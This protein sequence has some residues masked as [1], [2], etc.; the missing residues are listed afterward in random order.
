M[1]DGGDGALV[2]V[3][4]HGHPVARLRQHLGLDAGV[5]A[6]LLHVLAL[7]FQL[8]TLEGG[9]LEDLADSKAGALEAVE[10]RLGFDGF[11]AVDTD[12]ADARPF[13]DHDHEHIAIAA[14]AD[15]VEVA[16]RKETAGRGADTRRAGDVTNTDG[17][18]GENTARGDPL[19]ALDT[20]VGDDETLSP[21]QGRHQPQGKDP[22]AAYELSRFQCVSNSQHSALAAPTAHGAGALLLKARKIVI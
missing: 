4:I 6:A 2:H 16:G 9:A 17:H 5:V 14:D 11:V 1:L 22:V 7:Q 21:G 8:H 19:Q 15:I 13:G 18:G 20:D 12:L 10:Q 3:D